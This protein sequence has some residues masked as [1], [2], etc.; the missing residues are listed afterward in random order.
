MCVRLT[1]E[2]LRARENEI[3]DTLERD[4]TFRN[5]LYRDGVPTPQIYLLERV[6]V[7]FV[8]REPN[9]RGRPHPHDMR[10]EVSD[11]RFRPVGADGLREDRSR[12]AWWNGKAGMFAHAVSAALDDEPWKKAFDRFAKGGWNHDVVNRY[13]YLQIKK[14]GGT[15]SANANEIC[16]HA[17]RYAS[18]LEKQLKL[19]RPHLVLGCGVGRDSPSKLLAEHVIPR[20]HERKTSQG[21]TWWKFG[22]RARPLAMLQ[23][24]H[25]ARYGSR[26]ELYQDVWQAVRDVARE[27][28]LSPFFTTA[29]K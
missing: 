17:R 26:L 9:M 1:P 11:E 6:R 29:Q 7:V 28:T 20:G 10:D 14:V 22:A 24:W 18:V 5:Q 21:T 2:A 23:L 15:G 16:A 3:F 4:K 12:K 19:Y 13:A 8:F 25:P 27:L